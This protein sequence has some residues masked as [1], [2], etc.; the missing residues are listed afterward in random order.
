[1]LVVIVVAAAGIGVVAVAVAIVGV[2]YDIFLSNDRNLCAKDARRPGRSRRLVPGCSG[3]QGFKVGTY[4][5]S[6]SGYPFPEVTPE[7]Q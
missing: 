1:M 5:A 4:G 7:H 6:V 2:N 3:I